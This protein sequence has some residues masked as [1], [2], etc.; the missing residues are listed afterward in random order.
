[1]RDETQKKK[2][3]IIIIDIPRALKIDRILLAYIIF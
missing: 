1:M 3:Q 2:H